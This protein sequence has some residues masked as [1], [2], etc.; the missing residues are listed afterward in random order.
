MN[1]MYVK[2]TG[3]IQIQGRT[4]ALTNSKFWSEG[5]HVSYLLEIEPG[6]GSEFGR[7]CGMTHTPM[8][9]DS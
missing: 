2:S 9:H 4:R 3:A 7:P 1:R 6:I 5:I 8:W